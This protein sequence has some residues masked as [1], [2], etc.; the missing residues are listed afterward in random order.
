MVHKMATDKSSEV[1]EPLQVKAVNKFGDIICPNDLCKANLITP[2]DAHLVEGEGKCAVCGQVFYLSKE[3][4][5]EGNKAHEG[6]L[7]R[8]FAV[9]TFIIKKY[10]QAAEERGPRIAMPS[11]RLRGGKIVN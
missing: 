6:V 1:K 2:F 4:A 7:E 9:Q 3:I 10:M 11:A 5:E 8:L